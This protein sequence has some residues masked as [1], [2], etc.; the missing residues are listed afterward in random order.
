MTKD[1]QNIKGLEAAYVAVFNKTLRSR[2]IELLDEYG[3]DKLQY[4]CCELNPQGAVP[5]F[6]TIDELVQ[7]YRLDG[8]AKILKLRNEMLDFL[9]WN[10]PNSD[11]ERYRTDEHELPTATICD[12]VAAVFLDE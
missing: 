2:L 5:C 11:F 4:L 9:I 3:I 1:D 10:D 8:D 6:W 12:V 7:H